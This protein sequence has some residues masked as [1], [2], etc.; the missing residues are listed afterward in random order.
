MEKQFCSAAHV[1]APVGK[2]AKPVRPLSVKSKSLRLVNLDKSGR[3]PENRLV[4]NCNERK[5][6]SCDNDVGNVPP[7]E[8][9]SSKYVRADNE[10]TCVGTGEPPKSPNNASDWIADIRPSSVGATPMQP[11]I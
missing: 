8:P 1:V 10:N 4:R 6:T 3:L 5:L 11:S 2:R 9:Y 7:N